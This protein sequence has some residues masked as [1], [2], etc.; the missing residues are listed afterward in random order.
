LAG[1]LPLA[2]MSVEFPLRL[3]YFVWFVGIDGPHVIGKR[4]R[5]PS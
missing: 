2:L 5:N 4:L 1:Y 3:I